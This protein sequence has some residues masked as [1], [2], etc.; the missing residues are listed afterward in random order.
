MQ[1]R[2]IPNAVSPIGFIRN[3]NS[4]SLV[5]GF[6]PGKAAGAGD[7]PEDRPDALLVGKLGCVDA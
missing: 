3:C 5:T 7:K 2:G 4:L 1:I 6:R